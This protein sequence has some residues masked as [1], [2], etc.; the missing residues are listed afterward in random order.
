MTPTALDVLIW[1]AITSLTYGLIIYKS[2]ESL[3]LMSSKSSHLW[4]A[5]Y[6]F[7]ATG[8]L[9]QVLPIVLANRSPE[10]S[11]II[12]SIAVGFFLIL[13]KRNVRRCRR[14]IRYDNPPKPL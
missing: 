14:E 7:L 11:E 12:F 5:V 9:F 10:A 8:A 6:V 13:D 2:I 1:Q 4:R 3:N